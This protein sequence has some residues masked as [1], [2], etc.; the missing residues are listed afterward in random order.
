MLPSKVI[1]KNKDSEEEMGRI[2]KTC[3]ESIIDK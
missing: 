3:Y 1:A 2:T